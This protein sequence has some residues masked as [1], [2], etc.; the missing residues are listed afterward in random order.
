MSVLWHTGARLGMEIAGESGL[1]RMSPLS[2]FQPT[3]SRTQR[4]EES[5]RGGLGRSETAVH[6][7]VVAPLLRALGNKAHY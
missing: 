2:Y 5:K 4:G 6:S 7:H 3:G 1:L